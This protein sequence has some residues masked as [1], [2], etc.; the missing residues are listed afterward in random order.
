MKLI[1]TVN[2]ILDNAKLFDNYLN[3]NDAE[4]KDFALY[5]LTYGKCFV[6]IKNKETYKF[7]PSKYIGY[8]SNNKSHYISETYGAVVLPEEK[9]KNNDAAYYT[10]DGRMSNK[11]INKILKGIPVKDE[12]LSDKF[13][14]FCNRFGLKGSYKKKF[15]LN[16]IEQ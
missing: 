3:S 10:F 2:D 8:Q 6:V 1:E 9:Q 13:I 15:W 5:C 7:Y 4:E 12:D 14:E 16:I 11:A